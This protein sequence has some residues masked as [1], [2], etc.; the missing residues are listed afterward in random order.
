[1]I[2][3]PTPCKLLL[4]SSQLEFIWKIKVGQYE[5]KLKLLKVLHRF[6]QLFDNF[7]KYVMF[8]AYFKFIYQP[9]E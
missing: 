6:V 9:L 5:V 4:I 2:K 8:Y 3:R 1:M 7:G